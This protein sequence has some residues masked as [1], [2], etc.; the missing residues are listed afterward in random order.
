MFYYYIKSFINRCLA[1]F[2]NNS[3]PTFPH[4]VVLILVAWYR[5]YHTHLLQF[6]GEGGWRFEQLDTATRLSLTEEKQRLEAQLA[7]IPKMQQRLNELCK[8]LGEDSVLKTTESSEGE[9]ETESS[10]YSTCKLHAWQQQLFPPS[11]DWWALWGCSST[12]SI[13]VW[14][15]FSPL[16]I[17]QSQSQSLVHLLT[18][19]H[20]K[21]TGGKLQCARILTPSSK[22]AA[23]P[24][25]LNSDFQSLSL[26]KKKRSLFM[27]SFPLCRFHLYISYLLSQSPEII[28]VKLFVII[29][30]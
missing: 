11:P 15:R 19:P 7:G 25:V 21:W 9:W 30:V 20:W 12:L 27:S 29:R 4:F 13:T 26:S 6:D 16:T 28:L 2:I 23:V 3:W 17:L 10:G 22:L 8:I 24:A 1:D 14:V 5:K 18:T